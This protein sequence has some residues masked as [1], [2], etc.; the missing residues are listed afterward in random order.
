VNLVDRNLTSQAIALSMYPRERSSSIY[1]AESS[2][3]T[4]ALISVYPLISA[5][6]KK[7]PN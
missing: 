7:Q 5:V 3:I 4:S 2:E 6:A 1:A